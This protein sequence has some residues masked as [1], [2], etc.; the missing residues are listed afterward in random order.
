VEQSLCSGDLRPR[1]LCFA[2]DPPPFDGRGRGVRRT[3]QIRSGTFRAYGAQGPRAEAAPPGSTL[4]GML[5]PD[6]SVPMMPRG[7][8][9]KPSTSIANA[10][11]TAGC[12]RMIDTSNMRL[13]SFNPTLPSKVGIQNAGRG[14]GLPRNSVPRTYRVDA[15]RNDEGQVLLDGGFAPPPSDEDDLAATGATAAVIGE[16]KGTYR[17]PIK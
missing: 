5:A 14:N 1:Q 3:E 16:D 17:A 15:G 6:I 9:P 4:P 2:L 7:A 13:L 12:R 10:T 8:L 11:D